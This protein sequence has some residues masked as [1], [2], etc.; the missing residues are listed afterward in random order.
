MP[1]KAS[2]YFLPASSQ[3]HTPS[4]RT[5]A[6]GWRAYVFMTWDIAASYQKKTGSVP[7]FA[8]LRKVLQAFLLARLQHANAGDVAFVHHAM[9]LHALG[10]VEQ[11]AEIGD[12]IGGDELP[13][14]EHR[15]TGRIR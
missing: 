6:T 14:N 8:G 15:D 10:G 9:H 12:H 1:A 2:I 3:S 5:K 13:R 7:G 11:V 4:P